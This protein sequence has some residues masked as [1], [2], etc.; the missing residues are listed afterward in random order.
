MKKN[1][2]SSLKK[3]TFGSVFFLALIFICFAFKNTKSLIISNAAHSTTG[4]WVSVTSTSGSPTARHEASFVQT[5]NKFYLLGGRK[6]KPVQ[7]FDPKNRTWT[8]KVNTPI[9][10]HHFQAITIDG[11][12]YVVGA[13]TG[14]YPHEKPVANIYIYNPATNKWITGASIPSSRRRGSSGVVVYN[15]KIY[16]VAGIKDGHWAGHV[17][18]L[19]EYDPATNKWR[20]LANAPRARDHFQAAVINGKLYVAAGRRSSA[21][22]NQTFNLTVPQVDVYEFATNKWTTLASSKNIPTQRA[23]TATAVLGEEVIII[24]GESGSQ[25]TAH[26]HTEALNVRTQTWRRLKDL[27]QGRH[28][29]QA[30]VN[31]NNI[32]IAAGCGNR[33]G[34]PEL[35]TQE[36]FYFD[37]RT[38]PTGLAITQSKLTAPTSLSFGTIAINSSS[39]KTLTLSNTTGNQAIVISSFTKSGASAFAFSSPYTVPFILA[40]GKS[41]NISLRF[42]PKTTGTQSGSLV[43]K[44]SGQLGSTSI[45]FNGTGKSST[46]RMEEDISK[47]TV[48][49][50]QSLVA[51]PNPITDQQFKVKLPENVIGEVP[52][53]IVNASG[54]AILK[55]K[56]IIE[57]LTSILQFN[58]SERPLN[59]GIYF[60]R[61][62][63]HGKS[64]YAKLLITTN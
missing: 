46:S 58:L 5:G 40:P 45:T 24:G 55:D 53:V 60:L 43:V 31:N 57:N 32:Y 13:F 28:G 33:G 36:A 41:V 9:E 59:S 29:T 19:D 49:L 27:K 34:T 56:L 15:K 51:Y 1:K 23:G 54:I 11:L 14:S 39:S 50:T 48:V 4:T 2:A 63:E 17:N 21:S 52:F 42:S 3:I 6:I 44:H 64:Y 62:N 16:V 25:S 18:W 26:K 38:S 8:N 7:V 37:S 47:E 30:I 61:M 12:I 22:T 35:N 20:I 10:L